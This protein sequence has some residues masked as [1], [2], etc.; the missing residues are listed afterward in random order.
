MKNVLKSL[1]ITIAF[2]TCAPTFTNASLSTLA[3]RAFNTANICLSTGIT[4]SSYLES[5]GNK[6]D[7]DYPSMIPGNIDKL[8]LCYASGLLAFG[9]SFVASKLFSSFWPYTIRAYQAKSL[10]KLKSNYPDVLNLAKNTPPIISAAT[11]D[12][13]ARQAYHANYERK[14]GLAPFPHYAT[15]RDT[16]TKIFSSSKA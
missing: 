2:L 6:N 8:H 11:A 12:F 15:L 10:L 3:R 7:E 4:F 1:F 16:I 9:P 13:I 14:A 5:I